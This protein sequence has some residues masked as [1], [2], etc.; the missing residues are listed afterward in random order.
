LFDGEDI[1]SQFSFTQK[2]NAVKMEYGER[3]E[4]VEALLPAVERL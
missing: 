2:E 1:E 3:E 4:S